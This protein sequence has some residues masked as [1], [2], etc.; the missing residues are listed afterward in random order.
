M[1]TIIASAA[2]LLASTSAYAS[3]YYEENGV[4]GIYHAPV[5]S[6]SVGRSTPIFDDLHAEGSFPQFNLESDLGNV[7]ITDEQPALLYRDGTI[8]V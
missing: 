2:I 5:Q 6:S 8:G 1:K 7:Q 3:D 4:D